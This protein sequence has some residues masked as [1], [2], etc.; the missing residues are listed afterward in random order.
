MK[1]FL[2][3]PYREETLEEGKILLEKLDPLGDDFS[4]LSFLLEKKDIE[5][6]KRFLERIKEENT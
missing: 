2:I 5:D 3:F 1:V 4:L 6:I